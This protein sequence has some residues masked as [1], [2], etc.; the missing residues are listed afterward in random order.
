[1]FKADGVI[2]GTA[3]KLGG[4]FAKDGVVGLV[5]FLSSPIPLCRRGE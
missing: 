2:G 4:P 1:M 3:Q 5:D